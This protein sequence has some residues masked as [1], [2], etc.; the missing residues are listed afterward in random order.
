LL[1]HQDRFEQIIKGF[2]DRRLDVALTGRSD[3]LTCNWD[4]P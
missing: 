2:E 1:A 3:P 4:V